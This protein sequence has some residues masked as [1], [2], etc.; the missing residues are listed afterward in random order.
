MKVEAVH[1]EYR[2]YFQKSN[3]GDDQPR[4]ALSD[5]LELEFVSLGG[6]E[7]IVL[8]EASE[9]SYHTILDFNVSIQPENTP[10]IRSG[11]DLCEAVRTVH[12]RCVNLPL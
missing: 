12:L 6:Q 9:T 11:N 3:D 1:L 4:F 2:E 10:M 8:S 7:F 5:L